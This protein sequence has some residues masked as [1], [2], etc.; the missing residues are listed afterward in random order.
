M[1]ILL[2]N[3]FVVKYLNFNLTSYLAGLFEMLLKQMEKESKLAS[4]TII[5]WTYKWPNGRHGPTRHGPD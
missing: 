5:G 1:A 2:D 4:H 3:Y